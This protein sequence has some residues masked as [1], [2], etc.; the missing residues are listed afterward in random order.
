MGNEAQHG[1]LRLTLILICA[2]MA[3]ANSCAGDPSCA[4]GHFCQDTVCRPKLSGGQACSRAGE[5]QSGFCANGVCCDGACTDAC[6][7]CNVGGSAGTCSLNPAAVA[8]TPANLGATGVP[9]K[10]NLAW[11]PSAGAAS[12]TVKRS[13]T[14]GSGYAVI[15][16]GLFGFAEIVRNL[17]MPESR[18]VVQAALGRLLPS[19]Q[20]IK[21]AVWPIFR[22]TGLGA[23][24]GLLPGNGAVLGPFASYT[25]E[26][27]L[28]ADPS[29]FGNRGDVFEGANETNNARASAQPL[30]IELPPPADLQ[31][32]EI[33]VPLTARAG[34][35]LELSWTV[36]NHA[37]FPASGRWTDAAYLS[38]DA[39]W[40]V[41]DRLLG[42]VAF[43][44]TPITGMPRVSRLAQS[45]SSSS[46]QV[47][48]PYPL[49][50]TA[51]N[52][53]TDRTLIPLRRSTSAFAAGAGC[54]VNTGSA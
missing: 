43:S 12:Y 38:A 21:Q 29:R 23:F 51:R 4:S 22:G 48:A 53:N 13:T 3:C 44:G 7:A 18:N 34:E 49:T 36:S 16:M 11:A 14:S 15:A 28:A 33:I 47:S 19:G 45:G 46:D 2:G 24:L 35:P 27:K 52:T 17:E 31:V 32:D 1:R 30:L 6:K 5:C 25:L 54:M 41:N 37:A 42:R 10:V 20:E 40:D 39:I 9:D 50:T 26:K 8:A